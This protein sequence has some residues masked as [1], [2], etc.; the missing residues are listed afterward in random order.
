[1]IYELRTYTLHQGKLPAYLELARTVGRPIRGNDYGTV[2]GYWTSEFGPLNQIWHLWSYAS[3]DERAKLRAALA[4]N[5][6]WKNEYVAQIQP[7]LARQDIRFLNPVKELTPPKTKGGFY[8]LRIYRMN[9]GRVAGWA[10]AFRDVMPV[11]EKYSQNVGIWT[12]EAPQPNEAL[13]M[14]NYPDLA[15]R[16]RARTELFKDKDWLA[17]VA[18]SAGAIIE[19][20]NVLLLPTD[21]S[22][23]K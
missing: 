9:P 1:M 18:N 17:F 2:H 8:E 7:L 6:R 15:T 23:M 14:W 19:M 4:Q 20:Q 12:G 10:Q 5:Q 21:Y 16:T 3:F 13:H 22:P 11:R